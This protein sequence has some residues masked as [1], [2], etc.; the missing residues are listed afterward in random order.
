ME[1]QM[2]YPVRKQIRLK[3][4]DYNQNGVYFLTLCAKGRTPIFSKIVGRG[5]LDAPEVQ[6]TEAGRCV[7]ETMIYL[8]EHDPALHIEASVIMPNHV[9]ILLAIRAREGGASGRPRLQKCGFR[10]SY[11]L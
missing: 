10:N 7:Q 11:P 2:E 9:H 8:T 4:Y 6:L 5:L 1:V 3:G